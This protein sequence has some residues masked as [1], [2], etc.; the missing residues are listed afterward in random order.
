M[1]NMENIDFCIFLHILL[2]I[3]ADILCI[4]F[5]LSPDIYIYLQ[6]VLHIFNYLPTWIF[7]HM[8][9]HISAYF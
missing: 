6:I 5:T 1:R 9:L 7:L 2:Y 3:L 4:F 8:F